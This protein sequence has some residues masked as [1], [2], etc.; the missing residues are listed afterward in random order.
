MSYG[1]KTVTT[2]ASKIVG[3][4]TN[5]H[6][7]V[8]YNVGDAT[9]FFGPDSSVTAANGIPLKKDVSFQAD[10]GGVKL[11]MGDVWAITAASTADLRYWERI[12]SR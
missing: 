11:Y 1:T 9:V 8:L 2:A 6:S 12:E 4:E 3:A 10:S 7:L 5:R